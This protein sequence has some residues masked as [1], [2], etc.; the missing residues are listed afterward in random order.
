MKTT[1]PQKKSRKCK[2][3]K[4][5]HVEVKNASIYIPI[6]REQYEKNIGDVEW[7]RRYLDDCRINYPEVFPEIL[8]Q[9]YKCVG[10]LCAIKENAQGDDSEDKK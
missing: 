10:F 1:T 7:F 6:D 2:R 9:G 8:D 4:Q 3:E 5:E